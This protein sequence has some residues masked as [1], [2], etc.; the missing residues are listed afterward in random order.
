MKSKYRIMFVGM[1]LFSITFSLTSCMEKF[2]E[3]EVYDF[4]SPN[5]FY[6]KESHAVAA[7]SAIYHRIASNTDWDNS[8]HRAALMISDYPAESSSAQLSTVPY[9]V[10]F[11]TYNWKVDTDGIYYVW[12]FFYQ[13]IFLANTAIKYIPDITEGNPE[14]LKRLEGE[15]RFLR[16]LMYLYLVRL[17][18]NVPLITDPENGGDMFPSNEGTTDAVFELIISDFKFAE[19]NLK[20]VYE[21]VNVGRATSGA[22]KTFLAKTYLTLAGYPWEKTEYYAQAA[23]KCEEIINSGLYKLLDVYANNFIEAFEHNNEYIFDVE[24]NTQFNISNWPNMFGISGQNPSKIPGWSSYGGTKNFFDDMIAINDS[25][26]DKRFKTNF[27]IEFIDVNDENNKKMK[28]GV[29]YDLGKTMYHTWKYIDPNE[30][31][32]DSRSSLNVH[33][34]R[35]SDVLLMHSEAVNNATGTAGTR[36][37]YYGINLVRERA[38]LAP[39]ANL[40]KEAFNSSLIWERVVEL[41]YE[42]HLWYDYKRMNCME[43]RALKKGINIGTD[44]K[45]YVYPIPKNEMDLNRNLVQHPSW[46]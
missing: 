37:K 1:L 11:D 20:D 27:I 8:F 5:N 46:K 45:R 16:A 30:T 13:T 23:T 42:G 28:W 33:L 43:E 18:E 24:Y 14:N 4:I 22:A 39:L 36:D 9:R 31:G 17:Y 12:R 41:C 32:T 10:E 26:V 19:A 15:A 7:V 38:G 44:K 2:L 3:E 29:D 40:D 21:A 35:Y 6:K 25:A 34:S